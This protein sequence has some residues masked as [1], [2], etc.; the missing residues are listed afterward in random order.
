MDPLRTCIACRKSESRKKLLRV[1]QCDGQIVVDD[2][3]ILPG[4]GAWVHPTAECAKH[5]VSRGT[6]LR[7]LKVSGK[8]DT[9]PLE[10]RL[11]RLMDN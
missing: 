5:I 8:P 6:V 2:R 9:S 7:A 10:N 3:A 11:K 1:V 4:R